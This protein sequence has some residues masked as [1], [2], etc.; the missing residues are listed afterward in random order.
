MDR[1]FQVL[2]KQNIYL[3]K[4]VCFMCKINIRRK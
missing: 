1:Y 4:R 2:K 3:N